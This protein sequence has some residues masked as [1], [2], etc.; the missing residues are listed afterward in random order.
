MEMLPLPADTRLDSISLAQAGNALRRRLDDAGQ[1]WRLVLAL[2]PVL[3]MASAS[4][5][6]A[7]WDEAGLHRQ[8]SPPLASTAS[9]TIDRE[10]AVG[11]TPEGGTA[12]RP[13]SRSRRVAFDPTT[14][15]A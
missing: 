10:I 11:G 5:P 14:W 6:V 1:P 13:T 15:P 7:G 4:G 12:S 2:L 9:W 3:I 8:V